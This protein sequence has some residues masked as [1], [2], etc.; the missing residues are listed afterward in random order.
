[1]KRKRWIGRGFFCLVLAVGAV[2]ADGTGSVAVPERIPDSYAQAAQRISVAPGRKLNLRCEGNRGP[3]VLLEAGSHADTTTWF[4]LQPLLAAS[5]KVCSYDRAGYGF[6]DEGPQPRS[7][8]AD[9][10]DLHALI[11]HAGLATPL[12]LVGHSR[13]S[14]IVR[15]YAERYPAD[16]G[17]L[18]LLDPPAQDIAAFAPDWA[19]QE[20]AVN[21]ERYAFIRQCATGAEHHQLA[22]PP[23]PLQRCVAAANPLASDKV[24]AATFAYKSTPAFWRTLLSELQD[25][26]VVFG[27]PVSSQEH[28]GAMPLMVLTASDTYADLS[29]DVRPSLEAARDKT[30]AQ[31]V[32]TSTRGQRV[33]VDQ[34][35]HDIQLDQP[36][37]VVDAVVRVT[38]QMGA[39]GR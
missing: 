28:H 2:H 11:H 8:D 20:Q 4:R 33:V 3:T 39:A 38:Q 32:A 29:S 36:Q 25:N 7:L 18:V 34:S 31:I 9:V 10:S 13:G 23:P 30:Q 19:K 24:N 21:D 26:A 1:M 12:V 6:S 35:S 5:T 27:Q 17:A 15:L 16:V 22:S 37:A 14:N